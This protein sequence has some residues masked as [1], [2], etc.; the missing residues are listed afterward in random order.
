MS[1]IGKQRRATRADREEKQ[2]KR[3]IMWIFTALV[4][5]AVIFLATYMIGN[6]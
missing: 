2:A 5:L 1:N 4:L 3:V 6:M